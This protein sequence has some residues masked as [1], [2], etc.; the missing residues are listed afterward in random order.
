MPDDD[1]TSTEEQ[2]RRLLADTRHTEPLPAD[3]A[4]RLDG[5][6]ADLA[7]ETP[8]DPVVTPIR[9]RPSAADLAAAHRR[10]TV[11]S[12]L[13]AAAAVVVVGV[14]INQVDWSGLSGGGDSGSGSDAVTALEA[15]SGGDADAGGRANAES[16]AAEDSAPAPATAGREA[17]WRTARLQLSSDD[18]GRKVASFQSGHDVA[19]LVAPTDG[20]AEGPMTSGGQA[21]DYSPMCDVGRLGPGYLVPVKYDGVR[22]WLVFRTPEGESQV[23]DLYLCGSDDPARSITLPTP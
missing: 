4:D 16:D 20:L 22:A 2:V 14:G 3:I 19:A 9:P 8:A 13:V 10:R 15:D 21:Y 7:A 6:L 1:L 23:V 18:F 17:K 11:R 12:W 5:V